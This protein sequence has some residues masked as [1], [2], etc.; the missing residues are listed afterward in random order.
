MSVIII[1]CVFSCNLE[2]A[3][4][5]EGETATIKIS[6]TIRAENTLSPIENAEAA[7]SAKATLNGTVK[8]FSE[9]TEESN[10][11]GAA[12]V[13]LSETI[14]ESIGD[15]SGSTP[16]LEITITCDGYESYSSQPYSRAFAWDEDSQEYI[17]EYSQ[18]V[19][20]SP[21]N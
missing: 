20:L 18:T 15:I 5:P 3:D 12:A 11:S 6:F 21:Q 7:V 17:S 16:K 13:T 2:P 8:S 14:E 19:Y 10:Y 4:S 1:I 9:E